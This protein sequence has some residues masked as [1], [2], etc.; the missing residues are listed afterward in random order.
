MISRIGRGSLGFLVLY[1][2][3]SG[4]ITELQCSRI[5][6]TRQRKPQRRRFHEMAIVTRTRS[7]HLGRLP[8]SSRRIAWKRPPKQCGSLRPRSC[9]CLL[10]TYS[11][12]RLTVSY[13]HLRAHE[14]DSYLV[15]R[16]L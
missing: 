14:T 1:G 5:S 9:R 2:I 10:E 15:C 16:L 8:S 7:L 4:S 11:S 6:I 3:S 13:T 12:R